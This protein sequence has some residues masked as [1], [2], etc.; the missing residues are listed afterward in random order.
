MAAVF[1]STFIQDLKSK[2]VVNFCPGIVFYNDNLSN[3]IRVNLFRGEQAYSG[4]GSVSATVVR[5]DGV[6]VPIT[7]GTLTGNVVEITL[8]EACFTVPGQ[9][10]VYIRVT[11]DSVKTTVFAGIFSV[12]LTET[13]DIIDPSGEIALDIADLVAQ[14][15]EATENIPADYAQLQSDVAATN[16]KITAVEN[17]LKAETNTT[18]QVTA[19]GDV[20]F[21]IPVSALAGYPINIQITGTAAM[22]GNWLARF[23]GAQDQLG[24]SGSISP[25]RYMLAIQQTPSFDV[26]S[27]SLTLPYSGTGTAKIKIT[28]VPGNN[29]L[30]HDINEKGFSQQAKSLLITILR[31]GT[32][33]VDQTANINALEAEIT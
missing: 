31:N 2:L 20:N 21:T 22:L 9:I 23:I 18:E 29:A 14:I 11:S 17:T 28:H 24:V 16:A 12:M 6:T 19:T 1:E 30:L 27:I 32:Y 33:A 13:D 4:G 25:T 15:N 3:K 8:T 10:Q 5:Q 7:N 26:T